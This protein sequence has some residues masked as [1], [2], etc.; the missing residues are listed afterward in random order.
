MAGMFG[1]GFGLVYLNNRYHVA[2]GAKQIVEAMGI[3]LGSGLSRLN[4]GR[5]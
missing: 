3:G 2:V 1:P 5:K 4:V